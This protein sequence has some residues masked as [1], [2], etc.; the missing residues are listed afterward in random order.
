MRTTLTIDED[1]SIK[2]KAKLKE[3]ENKTFKEIVNA[4]LRLG[5]MA[6]KNL[7]KSKQFRVRRRARRF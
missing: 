5:L 3:S 1:V 6:E 2:L 4:T 7:T